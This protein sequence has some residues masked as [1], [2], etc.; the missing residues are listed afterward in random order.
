MRL[1]FLVAVI[2]LFQPAL[3][4]RLAG[5]GS[6]FLVVQQDGQ[7]F[8]YGLDAYGQLG[9]G[10]A[11]PFRVNPTPMAKVTSA[12]DVAAGSGFSCLVDFGNQAK[13]AGSNK[14]FTLGDGTS[15]RRLNPTPVTDLSSGV[16]GVFAGKMRACA[17]LLSGGVKCW[18]YN[19]SGGL[20]N[21][22]TTDSAVPVSVVGFEHSGNA[23]QMAMGEFHTCVLTGQGKLLCF[24]GNG[25]GQLGDGTNVGKLIPTQVSSPAVFSAVGC[26]YYHTCAVV[27]ST[28]AVVCFGYNNGGQLGDGTLVDSNLPKQVFGLNS[29]AKSVLGSLYTTLVVMNNGTA[30]AFGYNRYGELGTEDLSALLTPVVFAD[31]FNKI[32]SMAGGLYATCVLDNTNDEVSCLGSNQYGQLG[33]GSAIKSSLTLRV[34]PQLPTKRPTPTPTSKATKVPTAAPTKRPTTAKPSRPTKRPTKEPTFRP[35]RATKVPTNLP[36]KKPTKL[37][38]AAPTK[39]TKRPTKA[40]TVRP[41][42][43]MPTKRPTTAMPTKRPTK[44]PT[45]KPTTSAPTKRPTTSAPTKRPTTLQP[46]TAQP[47]KRPTTLQP[48]PLVTAS[49][50]VGPPTTLQPT[51]LK[52]TTAAPTK[53]PTTLQPTTAQPTK[54][55]TTLQPSPLATASPVVGPPTTLQPTSLKP[56]TAT[57]T[58]RPTTLQ[59]SSVAPTKRPTTLQPS[60]LPTAS[61]VVGPPTTLQPTSLKP[62]TATPT[63]RPTTLQPSSVAPTKRPTTLQPSLLPTASPVVGPPTT[64]QPTTS[65]PNSLE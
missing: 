25:S 31:G 42:T 3:A 37:P 55:P 28:G 11:A 62:T 49:P 63:K 35:T 65:Q 58:K 33:Q 24:G 39:P 52:P 1:I 7:V 61:P 22:N 26:G 16:A 48:S 59:P 8:G 53:R 38:T 44:T 40:P 51:S 34:M 14:F 21:G 43:N 41:T 56:T 10:S 2:A 60:L 19:S 27:S 47:T 32:T 30:R 5:D 20:G 6:F 57:P 50:V 23:K 13:C 15:Q 64:L 17:V 29:G 12:L 9:S 18:G 4:S 36:T 45:V 54:R 46:T